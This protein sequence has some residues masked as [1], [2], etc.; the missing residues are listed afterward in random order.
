MITPANLIEPWIASKPA[1][2]M[3][4]VDEAYAEFVNDLRFRSISPM[5]TQGAENIILLKTFSK[6]H[7]MAGMRVGNWI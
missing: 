5:I 7:A 3:F 1:N 2:T 4:I 6:I